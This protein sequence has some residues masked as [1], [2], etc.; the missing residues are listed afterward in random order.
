[1]KLETFYA[2]CLH[3][4]VQ[5]QKLQFRVY[6]G[7]VAVLI[8]LIVGVLPKLPKEI[9]GKPDTDW[10]VVHIW[11]DGNSGFSQMESLADEVESKVLS[12]FQNRVRYT[13]TKIYAPG[14][15]V[16]MARLKNKHEMRDA[17]KELEAKFTNTPEV[18]YG[19]ESWNPAELP[20]PD[21]PAMQISVE[22][23]RP[24]FARWPPMS[25]GCC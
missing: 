12:R 25:Y 14:D 21:F 16:V 2:D 5:N 1:M 6:G 8:F 24:K 4:F 3:R 15:A 18:R 7:L 17:M 10:V 13:Y 19:I 9:I 23:K 22:G 20:I 11:E